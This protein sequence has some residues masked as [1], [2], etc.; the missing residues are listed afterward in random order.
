MKK[1][2][3]LLFVALLCIMTEGCGVIQKKSSGAESVRN[4]KKAAREAEKEYKALLRRH[5]RNQSKSTLKMMRRSRIK[6]KKINRKL[7][8]N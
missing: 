7:M 2:L 5:M 4:Q 8:S 3:L 1:I 6:A